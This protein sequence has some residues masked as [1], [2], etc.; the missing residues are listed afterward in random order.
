MAATNYSTKF[1][2]KAS[3][4]MAATIYSTQFKNKASS[5]WRRGCFV[6]RVGGVSMKIIRLSG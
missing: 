2:N 5:G 4:R 1:R 6:V 3:S